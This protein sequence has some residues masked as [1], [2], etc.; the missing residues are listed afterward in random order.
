LDHKLGDRVVA[1]RT[2]FYVCQDGSRRQIEQYVADYAPAFV[3]YSSQATATVSAEMAAIAKTAAVPAAASRWPLSI[4]AVVGE[5]NPAQ[6]GV[7]VKVQWAIRGP[8]GPILVNRYDEYGVP[9]SALPSGQSFHVG[10]RVEL[11]TNGSAVT[12]VQFF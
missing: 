1:H 4:F 8:A 11:H 6:G 3:L 5:V 10:D 12:S 7:H 9:T 2:W